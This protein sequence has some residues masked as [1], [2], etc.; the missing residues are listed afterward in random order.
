MHI[1]WADFWLKPKL[2]CTY[3]C[4]ESPTNDSCIPG[5]VKDR[6]NGSAYLLRAEVRFQPEA[7]PHLARRLAPDMICHCIG[8]EIEKP[9]HV[10]VMRCHDKVVELVSADLQ[11]AQFTRI[12]HILPGFW[13]HSSPT[14]GWQGCSTHDPPQHPFRDLADRACPDSVQ[15]YLGMPQ[16]PVSVQ[17]PWQTGS[18]GEPAL[19]ECN[20]VLV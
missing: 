16:L 18:G 19:C 2:V 5:V 1:F 13:S 17:V 20:Q 12:N 11:A 7:F 4:A 8:A 9:R 15:P 10:Q 6:I 14:L 3:L